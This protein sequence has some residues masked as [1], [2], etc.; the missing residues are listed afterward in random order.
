MNNKQYKLELGPKLDDLITELAKEK[1][2]DPAELIRRAVGTYAYLNTETKG[3]GV[4]IGVLDQE[5]K[6][7]KKFDLP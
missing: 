5:D 2:V 4:T 7:L 6:P 3:E 1:G